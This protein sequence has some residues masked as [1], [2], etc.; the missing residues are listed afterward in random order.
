MIFGFTEVLLMVQV[1]LAAI[2]IFLLVDGVQWVR[3]HIRTVGLSAV[4]TVG[5]IGV[6][7]ML[8]SGFA[9]R[10]EAVWALIGLMAASSAGA[11][12]MIGRDLLNRYSRHIEEVRGLSS[13]PE[14]SGWSSMAG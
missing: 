13:P 2:A 7:L 8:P 6:A 3:D 9:E 5:T 10:S 1:A 14:V 11:G 12:L 4:L